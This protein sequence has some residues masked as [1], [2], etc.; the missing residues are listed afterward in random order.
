ME[1]LG[2]EIVEGELV[3]PED[4][5]L[6]ETIWIA[7]QLQVAFDGAAGTVQTMVLASGI[8]CSEIVTACLVVILHARSA[9][10]LDTELQ[11]VLQQVELDPLE[12]EVEFVGMDVAGADFFDSE[13]YPQLEL[14]PLGSVPP[15]VRAVFKWVQ[16]DPAAGPQTATLS[17]GLVVRRHVAPCYRVLRDT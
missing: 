11:V 9:W 10:A 3:D 4:V 15:R 14:A 17:V 1:Q 16:T 2:E 13:R 8:D 6:G 12:P 5:A 7:R